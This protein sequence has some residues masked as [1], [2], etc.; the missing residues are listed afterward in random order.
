M[1]PTLRDLCR[2]LGD[3]FAP[4]TPA[5]APAVEVSAVHVSELTDPTVYL[6]G[7]ELLLTTG[8]GFRTSAAWQRE[9]VERLTGIG[10]AGLVLG[11]GPAHA[12]VPAELAT[13]C[14]RA[15]LPLLVVPAPTPFLKVTRR[16][17]SMIA[18][19]GQRELAETLST[20]RALLAILVPW[21]L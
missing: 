6:D 15:G 19:S 10:V 20:H 12:S 11:L 21:S 4:V 3:D 7:G 16:Y 5:L 14:E 2:S 8:L 13:A 18:E 1:F 9:Y 17:W